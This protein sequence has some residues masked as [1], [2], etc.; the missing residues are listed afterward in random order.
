MKYALLFLV[1][2]VILLSCGSDDS[3]DSELLK[4]GSANDSNLVNESLADSLFVLAPV[5]LENQW[6]YIDKSG[7]VIIT[8]V[9]EQAR[10]FSE[11]LAAVKV[12]NKWGFTNKKGFASIAPQFDSA[13]WF[14]EGLAPVEIDGLWGYIDKTGALIISQQFV[15]AFPFSDGLARVDIGNGN[16][17]W[18]I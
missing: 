1:C 15:S 8:P 7:N 12:N 9:F 18:G 13:L 14:S 11:G 4:D 2:F 5:L 16:G 6:G 17:K 3:D 10:F